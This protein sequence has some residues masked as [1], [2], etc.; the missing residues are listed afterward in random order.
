MGIT[1]KTTAMPA[2]GTR[3]ICDPAH[4][5]I[6]FGVRH[7]VIH[8]VTG[9]FDKFNIYVVSKGEDFTSA[10]VLFVG[11][12][13]SITSHNDVL[14]RNLKSKNFFD[15][16]HHPEIS[17]ESSNITK[18]DDRN[19]KLNGN[20]SIRGIT[21][22][23]TLDLQS[24]GP[25]RGSDGIHITFTA[26]GKINRK[27]F[28]IEWGTVMESGGLVLSDDVYINCETELVKEK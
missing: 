6:L 20:L 14:A 7:M 9:H 13:D 11:K 23:V 28:G 17:F 21:K 25:V 24:E 1:T 15:A 26:K 5:E 22:P 18:T 19:F 3:W 27:D 8:S 4:S 12:A 16:E 2:T 10:K